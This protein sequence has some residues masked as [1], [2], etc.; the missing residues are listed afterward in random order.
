M[1]GCYTLQTDIQGRKRIHIFHV[2]D[3]SETD[4]PVFRQIIADQAPVMSGYRRVCW[5]MLPGPERDDG[6]RD[7]EWT[8]TDERMGRKL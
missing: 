8:A 2:Y 4:M 3:V 7:I 1:T 6:S 5:N